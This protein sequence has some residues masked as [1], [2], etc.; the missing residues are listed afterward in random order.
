MTYNS[1]TLSHEIGHAFNLPHTFNGD[2][3]GDDCPQNS[4]CSTQGDYSCDTPP[5]KIS[6]CGSTNPCTTEG[7]WDNSRRNYM[8]YCGSTNRFTQDQKNRM[9]ASLQVA[10]RM[11]LLN[12]DACQPSDF[13]I[14]SLKTNVS[15]AGLCDGSISLSTT[16]DGEYSYLWGDGAIESNLTGLCPGEYSVTINEAI[17]GLSHIESFVI[18]D[19]ALVNPNEMIATSDEL[20][21]CEGE[22]ALLVASVSG[23]YTWSNGAETQFIEVTESGGYALTV[24][25][26]LGCEFMSDTVDVIVHPTPIVTLSIP[27]II[28]YMDTPFVLNGGVPAGGEYSGPGVSEGSFYPALAG[29]G[30]HVVNY[31]YTDEFGCSNQAQQTITVEPFVQSL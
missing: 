9:H 5:H 12:S 25:T 19:A 27:E 2:N 11:H 3:D 30:T 24:N 23:T 15:C 31:L 20:T 16:C 1:T 18:E 4:T 8:S 6:D 10:P 13:G 22:S 26:P 17:S 21:F 28:N 14:T 29:V 7:I